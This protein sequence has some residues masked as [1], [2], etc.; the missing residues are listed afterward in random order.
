MFAS[1]VE[2]VR[3]ELTETAEKHREKYAKF[4]D[5]TLKGMADH[6]H[7]S[8]RKVGEDGRNSNGDKVFIHHAHQAAAPHY[9]KHEFHGLLHAMNQ[10]G[11]VEL[12]RADQAPM[13]HQ[14][15]VDKSESPYKMGGR[16]VATFHFIRDPGAKR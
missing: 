5:E 8:L 11:H 2:S 13:M 4:S 3:D 16:E 15:H 12:H 14:G 9:K 10:K 7:K 6:V 1:L